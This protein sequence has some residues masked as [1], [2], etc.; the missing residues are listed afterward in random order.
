MNLVSVLNSADPVVTDHFCTWIEERHKIYLARLAGKPSP[1]TNDPILSSNRFCNVF[2]CADRV[3]QAAIRV[4]NSSKSL[5]SFRDQFV[6][7]LIFRFFN[8]EDTWRYLCK[9]LGQ[10]PSADNFDRERY[11]QLL[12]DYKGVRYNA[13]YR[14]TPPI[15][16][17]GTVSYIDRGGRRDHGIQ[18]THVMQLDLLD[19]FLNVDNLPQQILESG[20]LKKSVELLSGYSCVGNFLA[21]QWSVDLGYGPWLPADWESQFIVPG[22]GALKG[23]RRMFPLLKGV[24]DDVITQGLG[25]EVLQWMTQN[26]GLPIDWFGRSLQLIDIQNVYCELD[27]YCRGMNPGTGSGSKKIKTRYLVPNGTIK[28]DP[29][30][31]APAT[32][33]IV[34][35]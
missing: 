1:W 22:P 14:T 35:P 28:S 4:A 2:R 3:S 11:T 24:S 8:R 15:H 5:K 23:M 10:E 6:R 16:S 9:A 27:K 34:I 12:S 13:A 30:P 32:W 26:H 29:R 18:N 33:G 25:A 31:I 19:R 17:T 20:S 21:M 7:S